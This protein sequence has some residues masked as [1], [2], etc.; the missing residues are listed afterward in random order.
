MG[1][2][3]TIWDSVV[4]WNHWAVEWFSNSQPIDTKRYAQLIPTNFSVTYSYM[5]SSTLQFFAKCFMPL[6]AVYFLLLMFDLGLTTNNYSYFVGLIASQYILKRF[7]S[8]LISSGYVDVAGVFFTF[9]TVHTLL[10]ASNTKDE[11]EKI[12]YVMFGFIFAAGTV[13]TKQNGLFVFGIF[14]ILAYLTVIK[15]ITTL[16]T[17]EK[18]Q[19][20]TIIFGLSLIL[21]LPWYVFNELRILAGAKTNVLLLAS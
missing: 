5:R 21:L 3:F 1:S 14:P 16:T 20:M 4:S 17:R 8:L 2:V 12:R 10:K 19:K 6:F 7:Y 9:I 11:Q 15:N 13:L 18:I